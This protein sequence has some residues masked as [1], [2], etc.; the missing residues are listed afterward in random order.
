MPTGATIIAGALSGLQSMLIDKGLEPAALG[1]Q[2]GVPVDAW[3]DAHFEIPLYAFVEIY[4]HGAAMLGQPGIGW[5][6]GPR[7]NLHD[8]GELGEAL[9]TA[10]TVGSALRTFER[11][12][13]FIQSETDLQLTVEDGVATLTYRILNPDIWPRRQDAEFTLSVLTE[14]IR[15]G[16]GPNWQPDLICFE[17]TAARPLSIW[18]ET[19]GS[20]CLFDC[21]TNALSFPEKVLSASMPRDSGGGHRNALASLSEALANKA[22]TKSLTARTRTAIYEGLGAGT[23]DQ[24]AVARRL[25]LSR[26]SLHR[27]LGEEGLRFSTL[28]DDCRYRIARHALVD[29]SQSLAQIAFELDYSDQT[30]FER[31]FK[32]KTG[33]TPKQYRQSYG[34]TPAR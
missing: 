31:A 11:F 3:Q 20:F 2:S 15:R 1:R 17:H 33:M 12:I 27:H 24:E 32:R 5:Q 13:K 30:A 23:S 9:L 25:G 8:L 4:E 29:T 6:S 21:E 18:A 26:R 7:L 34:R 28:L 16:A 10:S 22:R 14:L 19:A